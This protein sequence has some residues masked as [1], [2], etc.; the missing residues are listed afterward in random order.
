M[1]VEG[2]RGKGLVTPFFSK[3]ILGVYST[4]LSSLGPSLCTFL[5]LEINYDKNDFFLSFLR[6]EVMIDLTNLRSRDCVTIL[7]GKAFSK[8]CRE[9]RRCACEKAAA[10]VKVQSLHEPLSRWR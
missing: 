9:L 1:E 2:P 3:L 4:T 6:F 5:I 10:M 8:D 7:N